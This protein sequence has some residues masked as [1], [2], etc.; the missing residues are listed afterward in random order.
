MKFKTVTIK[1][2]ITEEREVL[3]IPDDYIPK[4]GDVLLEF[5]GT[6]HEVVYDWH[7]ATCRAYAGV[8]RL[9]SQPEIV[10]EDFVLALL[11]GGPLSI[12]SVFKQAVLREY[13]TYDVR[14]ACWE[15]LAAGTI[16]FDSR[17]N[18]ALAPPE[19]RLC[20][21]LNGSQCDRDPRSTGH[22]LCKSCSLSNCN[23]HWRRE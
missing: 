7:C 14:E 2:T 10:V 18:L 16:L 19:R 23:H 20:M 1:H 9:A 4:T 22:R 3:D 8:V 11:K 15:L 12:E 6:E 5:D 13:A 17:R 21:C